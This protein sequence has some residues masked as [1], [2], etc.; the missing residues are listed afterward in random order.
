MAIDVPRGFGYSSGMDP[1]GGQS[2]T[3]ARDG[4]WH[5]LLTPAVYAQL[6]SLAES[7]LAGL[8]APD[9]VLQPT[10]LLHEAFVKLARQDSARFESEGHFCAVAAIAM[11]QLLIDHLR[12]KASLKRGGGAHR[13]TLADHHAVTAEGSVD[14]LALDDLLREFERLDPRAAR[15]VEMRFFAGG[16]DAEIG[17]TLGIS[18]RTVRNDWTMARAWLRTH[19]G[20]G[21]RGGG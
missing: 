11:R 10:A 3:S 21:A 14:L 12:A 19:L 20:A 17:R 9:S 13:L 2:D 4:S 18:E 16:S 5:S 8:C 6:R 1:S 15:V 7:Y